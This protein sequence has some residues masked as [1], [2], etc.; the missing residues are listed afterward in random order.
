MKTIF[1]L[2]GPQ[3][4]GRALWSAF[5]DLDHGLPQGNDLHPRLLVRTV[6]PS[7]GLCLVKK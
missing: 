1:M 3:D 5:V 7:A 6:H 4:H 2:S